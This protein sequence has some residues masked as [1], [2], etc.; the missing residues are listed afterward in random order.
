ML[1][2]FRQSLCKFPAGQEFRQISLPSIGTGPTEVTFPLFGFHVHGTP[3]PLQW[4]GQ[5][6][7]H[8]Q[9][10]NPG[11]SEFVDGKKRCIFTSIN[12]PQSFPHQTR[13]PADVE[14]RSPSPP[15]PRPYK[16]AYCIYA[17]L[18]V[19]EIDVIPPLIL[20]SVMVCIYLRSLNGS[21]LS[22]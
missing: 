8:M 19:G 3:Q 22:L 11:P 5:P 13:N 18:L 10:L 21:E 9:A 17:I 4:I 7:T 1:L 12:S 15:L 16:R 2:T 6:R 20:H 14:L